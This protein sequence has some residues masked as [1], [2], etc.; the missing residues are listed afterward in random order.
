MDLPSPPPNAADTDGSVTPLLEASFR[1]PVAV[2][3]R[4]N[5]VD[6]WQLHREAILRGRGPAG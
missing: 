6:Q 2:E 4:S 1:A 5:T 3:P